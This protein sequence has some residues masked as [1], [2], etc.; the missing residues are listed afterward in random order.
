[1][2]HR[3][4]IQPSIFIKLF[5]V[6]LATGLA[7]F[8]LI[9]MFMRLQFNQPVKDALHKNIEN[10]CTYLAQ[11][12]GS[13]PDTLLAREIAQS[14]LIQIY[15]E[16]PDLKWSS[17]KSQQKRRHFF[18]RHSR[19]SPA[20]RWVRHESVIINNPDGSQV[21]F[22][23]D[24]S[25]FMEKHEQKVALIFL[26]VGVVFIL[27]YL[28]IR[29]ILKPVKW[30]KQ[31]VIQVAEGNLNHQIPVKNKDELGE[32]S[33]SFNA[34]TKRI[35]E[36][37][38][39]R[40]QLLLDVSHELRSPITRMKVA[41][42]FIPEGK[43][44]QSIQDDISEMEIMIAEILETE[45]LKNGHGKLQLKSHN[46]SSLIKQVAKDFFERPP[47]IKFVNFPQKLNLK[48]DAERIRIVLKNI[49]ENAIKYSKPDS[50]PVE[51][52]VKE[53]DKSVTIQIKDD[54]MGIPEEHI[55]YLFEPF[56]RVDKSRSKET[57]GYG[58]GLSLC[59]KIMEAHGGRIE[60]FKNEGR[61]VTV[62]LKFM[63]D[64]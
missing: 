4:K 41:L 36:M 17:S 11:Q 21:T 12:I 39:A 57:G 58:L 35:K 14:Y 5:L 51:I 23:I 53:E 54:G 40:D 44:K 7:V 19:R 26:L 59:K 62:N 15:Y 60:V 22:G 8:M 27:S 16:S 43:N 18:G 64:F 30:L 49:L 10:Y 61:G 29:R 56:Y 63:K 6:M 47:G 25:K 28:L 52:S 9:G 33:A 48:I 45:R 3:I 55:P 37:I 50:K 13:P 1:M 38:R 32:L 24:Q 2:N 46:I 20:M 34:M 42:E 31:G